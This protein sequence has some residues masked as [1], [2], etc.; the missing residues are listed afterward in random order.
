MPELIVI[1]LALVLL[2]LIELWYVRH[3]QKTISQH[4]QEFVHSWMPA[5]ALIGFV[6]G[7]ALCHITP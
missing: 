5:G 2:S 7:W 6:A 1:V 4:A 3:N